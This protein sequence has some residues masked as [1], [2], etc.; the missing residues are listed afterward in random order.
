MNHN[1]KN[2]SRIAQLGAAL[3]A[4]V[5]LGSSQVAADTLTQRL[6]VPMSHSNWRAN[7]SLPRFD[8]TLGTLTGVEIRMTGVGSVATRI[9][10]RS[11]LARVVSSGSDL[12]IEV[13]DASGK[14]LLNV[15]PAVRHENRLTRFDG[16]ADCAG[17]SGA[18]NPEKLAIVSNSVVLD[19]ASIGQ[20]IGAGN[21]SLNAIAKAAG[22]YQ[23]SA[24]A[25]FQVETRASLAVEVVYTYTAAA[26]IAAD[27]ALGSIGNR[28]WKDKDEDGVQEVNENGLKG[29]TVD[30]ISGNQV[31]ATAV[32]G[33]DGEYLFTDVPAGVY[34]VKV[35]AKSG[36][37]ATADLDGLATPGVATI[38]VEAG[39]VIEN[40]DFGFVKNSGTDNN[41]KDNG[42]DEE[43][44]DD[45][46][47]SGDKDDDNCDDDKDSKGKN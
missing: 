20:F 25:T 13:T 47:D 22:F 7:L 37:R 40:A 2:S 5:T 6:E 8:S 26:P 3:L 14:S 45:D 19:S 28:V 38:T 18:S 24:A 17:T 23:G 11:G 4:S 12:V 43:D 35:T 42:G 31:I 30:L 36:Y 32:T 10:N 46:D 15:R 33:N 34:Q 39:A 21:L 27:E 44:H 9:E 29:W 1:T 41:D 16:K